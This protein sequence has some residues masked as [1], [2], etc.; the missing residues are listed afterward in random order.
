VAWAKTR[1][2]LDQPLYLFFIDHGSTEKFLLGHNVTD[3]SDI[4]M[5][6]SQ[7]K[8]FLDDY[9]TTNNQTV[10]VIDA[11]SS[12]ALLEKLSPSAGRA[13][14]SST[15]EGK[16][17][18]YE[19]EKQGFSRFMAEALRKG[20]NFLEAFGFAHREQDKILPK[21]MAGK[22]E[23]EIG[24]MPQLN[25]GSN[26]EWLRTLFVNGNFPRTNPVSI[27]ELVTS[28]ATELP[29]GQKHLLKGK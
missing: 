20:E 22:G 6:A 27:K 4:T 1:G 10:A 3:D 12:G 7:F 25:D 13:I 29:A 26:G 9:S 19:A 8:S 16:A 21:V 14:V 2:K 23:T 11:C 17:Y 24:Q 28:G 15:G 5:E 18:F